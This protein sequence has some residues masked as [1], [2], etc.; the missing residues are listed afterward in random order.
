M[1]VLLSFQTPGMTQKETADTSFFGVGASIEE[2]SSGVYKVIS[3]GEKAAEG[4]VHTPDISM[5]NKKWKYQI[6]LKGEGTVYWKI[7]ETNARGRFMKEQKSKPILLTGEWK[8]Y[9]IDIELDTESS[10]IDVFVLTSSDRQT[11]FYFRNSH[12]IER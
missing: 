11:K 10:Q 9:D 4:F 5:I 6:D 8:T 12:V 3:A 1:I 7:E 2:I